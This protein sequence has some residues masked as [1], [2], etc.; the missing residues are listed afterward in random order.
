MIFRDRIPGVNRN[1]SERSE[2]RARSGRIGA[3]W[4]KFA[5]RVLKEHRK[6]EEPEV[7]VGNY[8][9]RDG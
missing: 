5:Q 3:T 1:V 4:I 2:R 8:S 7:T 6:V 9:P